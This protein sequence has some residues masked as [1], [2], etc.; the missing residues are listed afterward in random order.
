[1][2]SVNAE[3]LG[4]LIYRVA[5]TRERPADELL[6]RL[7]SIALVELLVVTEAEF[8]I[9]IPDENLSDTALASVGAFMS[10]IHDLVEQQ[11]LNPSET[12]R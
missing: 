11:Q 9:V 12:T 1:M 7:D 3:R 6:P 10:V 2:E 5:G 8:E 4:E